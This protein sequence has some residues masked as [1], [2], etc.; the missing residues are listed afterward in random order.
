MTTVEERQKFLREHYGEGGF[1][2]L[3]LENFSFENLEELSS[4]LH[5]TMNFKAFNH[6]ERVSNFYIVQIPLLKSITTDP[7]LFV[8]KRYNNLDLHSIFQTGSVQQN[9]VLNIPEK[10]ELM[11]LPED[12][13]IQN[14]FGSYRLEFEKTNTG[15]NISRELVFYTRLIPHEKYSEFKNFYL[16]LLDAD[17]TKLA[18]KE[19]EEGH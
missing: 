8:K 13:I 11:E 4:P 19:R 12:V 6:V 10:F 9:I 18:L 7:S 17:R 15:I 5:M 1:D 16:Q 3:N 2:N 14:E